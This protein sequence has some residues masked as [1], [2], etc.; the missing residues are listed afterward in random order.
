MPGG[1][2]HFDNL[3]LIAVRVMIPQKRR[4]NVL[5]KLGKKNK[6]SKK[7]EQKKMQQQ[8][9]ALQRRNAAKQKKK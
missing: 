9:A 2:I 5:S 1:I 3:P 7:A 4:C 6:D 8:L